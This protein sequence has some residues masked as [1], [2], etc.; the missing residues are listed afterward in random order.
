MKKY[1]LFALIALFFVSS[2]AWAQY[3]KLTATD[4]TVSWIPIS[5]NTDGTNI[6]IGNGSNSAISNYTIGAIDLN[7]VWSQSDGSGT[8]YQV[9]SIGDYAFYGC[10]SLTSIDIPSG[11]TSIGE[12]AFFQCWGLT[13]IEIPNSV[14]SIGVGAFF[15]CRGLTSIEIPNSVTSI[16]YSAFTGCRGLT[17]ITIPNSVNSIE[18]RAF[19]GCSSLTSF[20]IPNSVT[21]IGNYAFNGCTGLTSIVIPNS[22]TTIEENA[23]Y[24]C[25][26][27]TSIE[28]PNSVTTIGKYAFSRC[29][30][31]IK[32]IVKDIAAWCNIT[33]GSDTSNPLYYAHHIYSDKNTEITEL[34][35]PNSVTSIGGYAFNRCSGLTSITIPNNV[36]SI[37]YCAF[38]GCSDLKS[39]TSY[40]T[41]VFKTGEYAFYGCDHATL[42]VPK[43]LVST[44]Q[45]TAD[46]NRFSTIE[47]MS[48][49]IYRVFI[50]CNNKGKVLI[51]GTEEFTNDLGEVNINDGFD[52]TFIFQPKENCEL[53]QVLI[54]GLDVTSSVEN[55]QLTT[56]VHE[57]S[58]MMVIFDKTGFDVN[59]DGNVDISDVV[60]LVNFILGQ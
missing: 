10:S 4:G 32:V 31:L 5:G 43:G 60:K 53:R 44:Y 9:T 37:G 21:S 45:S 33:F 54:D 42:Y 1:L 39:L 6:E 28:I 49:I 2:S 41:E 19:E 57:G 20:E 50:S 38:Y 27:L 35:I 24:S 34:I 26:G 46:W 17:S 36:T 13:S 11:V 15:Q 30:S 16:G 18:A 22:V 58:K 29:S 48:E 52:N 56:K 14:T 59:G 51:N 25:T 40:I 7:E 55:N 47:E 8:H 23:F 12:N 3:V